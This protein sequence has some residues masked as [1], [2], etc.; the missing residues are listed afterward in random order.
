MNHWIIYFC[1]KPRPLFQITEHACILA[2]EHNT[3]VQATC[4]PLKDRVFHTR[5]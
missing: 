2:E 3:L 5:A 1:H 4:P